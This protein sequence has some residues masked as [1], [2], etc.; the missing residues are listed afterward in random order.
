MKHLIIDSPLVPNGKAVHV[1]DIPVNKI[2]R[3]YNRLGI[4]T[5]DI[6]YSVRNISVY[7]CKASAYEFY[8]PYGL[9]GSSKFYEK[10]QKFE[11]YYMHWKWEHEVAL[12]YLED[13][14]RILEVGCAHGAFLNGAHNRIK[15]GRSIGLELNET[16]PVDNKKFIII[17]S[18]IQ[19]FQKNNDELFDVV[20]SFQVLEHISD[21]H[22]FLE[23]KIN[24][25]KRYGKLLISVPNNESFVGKNFSVLNA[26]PHHV[27]LWGT[28]SL[29]YLENLFPIKLLNMHYESLQDYH[30]GSYIQAKYYAQYPSFIAYII[31]KMHKFTGKYQERLDHAVTTKESILGHT[32]LAVF[33]KY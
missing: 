5:S 28:R 18:S 33:Q 10:L 19:N 14:Q 15:L 31:K 2:I 30:I 16:A 29:A 3:G 20:C 17:N 21:V 11:W 27:G 26:P 9:D 13:G 4:D 22:S 23:A 7:R 32:V 6:F 24:C 8:Q 12:S 1:R 25:L